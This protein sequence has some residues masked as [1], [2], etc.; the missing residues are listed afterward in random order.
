MMA[1]R[2]TPTKKQRKL[3][4]DDFTLRFKQRLSGISDA[5]IGG[6]WPA[7]QDVD[8]YS[9]YRHSPYTPVDWLKGI[10]MELEQMFEPIAQQYGYEYH[11][12]IVI[13]DNGKNGTIRFTYYPKKLA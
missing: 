4:Y 1:K 8:L 12:D 3:N 5:I 7:D 2:K 11:F 6:L 9:Q 13:S 10:K